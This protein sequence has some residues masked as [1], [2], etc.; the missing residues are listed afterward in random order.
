MWEYVNVATGSCSIDDRGADVHS[1][2]TRI[3]I[4]V[5]NTVDSAPPPAG[6]KDSLNYVSHRQFHLLDHRECR[7]DSS[8]VSSRI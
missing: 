8:F 5:E 6:R 1:S 3:E 4:C 7:T 2:L